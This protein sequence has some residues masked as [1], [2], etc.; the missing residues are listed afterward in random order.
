MMG[1]GWGNGLGNGRVRRDRWSGGRSG[2]HW[3]RYPRVPGPK[4]M[5]RKPM[6]KDP[7]TVAA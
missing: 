4:R 7:S 5:T 1:E 2:C 6:A 3:Y